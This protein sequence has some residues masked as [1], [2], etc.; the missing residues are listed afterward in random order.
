M[1][2]LE[3][4]SARK[5][6]SYDLLKALEAD[7][8]RMLPQVRELCEEVDAALAKVVEIQAD[9][10]P[11]KYKGKFETIKFDSLIKKTT[12]KKKPKKDERED[13]VVFTEVNG[14][15]VIKHAPAD[16]LAAIE[17]YREQIASGK[18]EIEYVPN[19]YKQ[20]NA[21]VAFAKMAV[22]T[23]MLTVEDFQ[24]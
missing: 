3:L 9:R 20:Y 7:R 17:L 8:Q 14:E 22:N 2:V 18:E 15:R 24:D 23:G 11:A 1:Q 16:R 21:M 19:E 12:P 5:T 6:P 13:S 4:D 10:L